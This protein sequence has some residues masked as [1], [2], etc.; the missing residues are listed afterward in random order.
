PHR[1]TQALCFLVRHDEPQ[2]VPRPCYGNVH[3]V[4]RCLGIRRERGNAIQ[5]EM[6]LALRRQNQHA[7]KTQSFA[8]AKVVAASL[9]RKNLCSR[10]HVPA[11]YHWV[12]RC[13]VV[14]DVRMLDDESTKVMGEFRWDLLNG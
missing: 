7:I 1:K 6:H 8:A 3:L 4:L 11:Q 9:S 5:Y 10:S 14:I 12:I 13:D 2:A